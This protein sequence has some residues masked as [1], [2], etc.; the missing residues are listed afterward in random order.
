M[1]SHSTATTNEPRDLDP[2]D[3]GIV[4][5]HR[6]MNTRLHHE[7]PTALQHIV[8]VDTPERWQGLEKKVMIAIHPLSGVTDPSAF[9]LE[10]GRLCVMAS[11]HQS[12]LILVSRDH[13]SDTL[14]R[15][16]VSAEQPVG[17]VDS[18]GLGHHRHQE[19]WSTLDADNR[20]VAL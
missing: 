9:E 12:G 18:S 5:T 13:V 16:I 11:R 6:T 3:I 4:S 19:F 7:L 8:R 15:H 14:R 1:V 2:S 10:T 20:L 17:R